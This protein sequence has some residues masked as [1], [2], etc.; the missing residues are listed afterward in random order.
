MK[1]IRGKAGIYGMVGG[2]VVDV[3]NNGKFV[4]EQMLHYVY[5]K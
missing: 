5:K 1:S 4:D 2:Q 3:E